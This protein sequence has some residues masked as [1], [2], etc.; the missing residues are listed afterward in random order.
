[1]SAVVYAPW[2]PIAF[3]PEKYRRQIDVRRTTYAPRARAPPMNV[4]RYQGYDVA[5][6]V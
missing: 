2:V 1:M 4:F 5:G 6:S 3:A